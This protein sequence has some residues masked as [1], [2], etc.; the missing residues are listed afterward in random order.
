MLSEDIGSLGTSEYGLIG[1]F[2][3]TLDTKLELKVFMLW[4]KLNSTHSFFVMQIF[5]NTCSI[6]EDVFSW[7]KMTTRMHP[8]PVI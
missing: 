1:K 2:K 5:H 3:G 8:N 6:F 7:I 4:K